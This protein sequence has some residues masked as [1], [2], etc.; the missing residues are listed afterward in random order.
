MHALA[1][2]GSRRIAALLLIGF[3]SGLPSMLCRGT[4]QTWAAKAGVS[5]EQLGFLQLVTLPF[6]LKFLAGPFLDAWD[7]PWL[8]R[9]RGWVISLQVAVAAALLLCSRCDPAH[10]LTP[11]AVATLLLA[12]ASAALDTASDG[13]RASALARHEVGAGVSLFVLGY[14]AALLLGGAGAIWYATSG[15]GGVYDAGRWQGAYGT[16]AALVGL[17]A[18]GAWL[19]PRIPADARRGRRGLG[20]VLIDPFR[21]FWERSGM[22]GVLAMA[23]FVLC[24]RLGDQVA[25]AMAGGFLVKH[26][27]SDALLAA[28]P[29]IAAGGGAL[30]AVLGGATLDRLGVT[31]ALWIFGTLQMLSN[32]GYAWLALRPPSAAAFVTVRVVEDV[33]GGLAAAAF[34]SFLVDRCSPRHAATQF[35]LFTSFM[36]VGGLAISAFA[37]VLVRELGWASFFAATAACA[38]PGLLLLPTALR[39][40]PAPREQ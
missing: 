14:R 29:L 19:A 23:A 24:F 13:W 37:G 38:L 28:A 15:T 26:G 32:L 2:L 35:A 25:G 9:R 36:V 17:G 27:Y 34:L 1:S 6:A 22:A 7:P 16:L 10:A 8:G 3:G 4:L 33:C 12:V 39:I 21:E 20:T 40:A 18:L 30:G 31:R 5:V 11:L